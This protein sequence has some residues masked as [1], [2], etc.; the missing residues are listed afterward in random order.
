MP[1]IRSPLAR[2]ARHA[3]AIRCGYYAT[4]SSAGIGFVRTDAAVAGRV[5]KIARSLEVWRQDV[6]QVGKDTH[7]PIDAAL[8]DRANITNEQFLNRKRVH[9]ERNDSAHGSWLNLE[10]G[11]K[12]G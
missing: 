5:K 2:V 10:G 9:R 8:A 4:H 12:V 11:R 7:R 3:S 1:H 6:I